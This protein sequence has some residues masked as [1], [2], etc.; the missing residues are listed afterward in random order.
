[1]WRTAT[2]AVGV[3][4]FTSSHPFRHFP[5]A[6][7]A[8]INPYN[9]KKLSSSANPMVQ[10]EKICSPENENPLLQS[11]SSEFYELPPFALI[12]PNHFPVAFDV[13]MEAHIEDLQAMVDAK[14][15]LEDLSQ[16]FEKVFA[17]YDRAGALLDRVSSLY[18]NYCGSLNTPEMQ[19]VQTAMSAVLARHTSRAYTLPGLFEQIQ[20][21][22]NAVVDKDSGLTSEQVRLV[23]RI[24]LDFTRQGA[25]FSEEDK[26]TYADIKA[27]LAQLMTKFSQNVMKDE[28]TW[29]M[30][31]KEEDM[32]GCPESLVEAAKGAATDRGKAEDEFVITLSRSLVEP[33]LTYSDRRDLR[34]KAFKAWTSRGE[35][36]PDRDNLKIGEKMLKLR[37]KQAELHGCKSFAEY[38]LQD[39]MAK[40]PAN[41]MELLENV[42][43]KAKVSQTKNERLWK[44]S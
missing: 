33:F 30:V 31:L 11:W 36:H 13:A 10:E 21:V 12:Q 38:Q 5:F 15:D 26:K 37:K 8:P 6:L 23:E 32:I 43:E 25:H 29:E 1:V 22:Y 27:E 39:R 14:I 19:E 44:H 9:L 42:W 17:A 24:Y 2:L 28:E 4:A 40:T 20:D 7:S 41:V 16:A 3:T 18:G 35:L 34:E